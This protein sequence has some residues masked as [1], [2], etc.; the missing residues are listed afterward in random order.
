MINNK[1]KP[2]TKNKFT[3]VVTQEGDWGRIGF[4]DLFEDH[5]IFDTSDGE[6]G[7]VTFPLELLKQKIR[8][9]EQE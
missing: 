9:H 8:E 6:Y 1:L 3:K 5:V 4:I 2:I 7:P